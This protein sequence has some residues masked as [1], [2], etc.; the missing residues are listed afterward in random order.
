MTFLTKLTLLTLPFCLLATGCS[1]LQK[2]TAVLRAGSIADVTADG[3]R[4]KFD[5]DVTNPNAVPIPL[6]GARYDLSLGRSKVLSGNVD[7]DLSIPAKGTDALTVPVDVTFEQL[8]AAEEVIRASG[9]DIPYTFAGTL[10]F[11]TGSGLPIPINVPFEYKGELPLR[12]LLS[13]PAVLLQNPQARKLAQRVLG[14][15]FGL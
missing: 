11:R 2:P 4:L 6:S 13:D 15:M 9:G 3:V 12:K 10:G 14:G 8:L 7:S 1:S 5:V